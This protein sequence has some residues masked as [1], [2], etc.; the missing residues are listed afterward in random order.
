MMC[1]KVTYAQQQ[2]QQLAKT[3]GENIDTLGGKTEMS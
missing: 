3:I 1:F 2:Q